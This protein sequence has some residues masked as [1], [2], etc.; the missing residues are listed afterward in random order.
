MSPSERAEV[1]YRL[2]R[3]A[4]VIVNHAADAAGPMTE[5][6]RAQFILRRLYPEIDE[7]RLGRIRADLARREAEGTWTGF[8]RP[9]EAGVRRPAPAAGSG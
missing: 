8:E 9:R 2:R 4:F 1:A 7:D 5:L 6:D 3:Q